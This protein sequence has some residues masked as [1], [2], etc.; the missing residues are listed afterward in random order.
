MNNE[1]NKYENKYNGFFK[2]ETRSLIDGEIPK[3]VIR[4]IAVASDVE[5]VAKFGKKWAKKSVFT[6]NAVKKMSEQMK[7]RRIFVDALHEVAKGHNISV[8]ADELTKTHPDDVDIQKIASNLKSLDKVGEFPMFKHKELSLDENGNLIVEAESV[9]EYALIDQ[10]HFNKYMAYINAIKDKAINGISINFLPTKTIF[11]DDVERIDDV[12]VFGYSFVPDAALANATPILE[13]AVRSIMEMRE[14][15]KME[16]EENEKKEE[17]KEN[18]Q[19]SEPKAQS[20][21]NKEIK[22]SIDDSQ[23][24]EVVKKQLED[25]KDEW[26]KTQNKIT[27]LMEQ[28]AK[29]NTQTK[30]LS[31]EVKPPVAT[32]H[33]PEWW[34]RMVENVKAEEG[35][36]GLVKLQA[37]FRDKVYPKGMLEL[38]RQLGLGLFKKRPDD[39]DFTRR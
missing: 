10:D 7:H 5:H 37:E 11:D 12:E 25:M 18:K 8:L 15:E 2:I 31:P 1:K 29:P 4:G 20:V 33:D 32:E 3:L 38:D 17:N 9:P 19:E 28:A 22:V 34:K 23:V 13:V 21:E 36:A 30:G 26:E 27:E 35:Y 6:E 14:V 24:K 16:N 39:L